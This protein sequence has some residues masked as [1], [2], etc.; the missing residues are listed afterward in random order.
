MRVRE[1]GLDSLSQG[2]LHGCQVGRCRFSERD[3]RATQGRIRRNE[4][5]CR[6][7]RFWQCG[8]R[9]ICRRHKAAVSRTGERGPFRRAALCVQ[10]LRRVHQGSLERRQVAT[11]GGDVESVAGCRRR[12]VVPTC[13]GFTCNRASAPGFRPARAGPA[14]F[15]AGRPRRPR[16]RCSSVASTLPLTR[17]TG[18]PGR[19]LPSAGSPALFGDTR[20]VGRPTWRCRPEHRASGFAMDIQD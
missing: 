15:A 8:S 3:R 16:A 6:K 20:P 13:P 11:G 18:S 12:R 7:A 5:A 9:P 4:G 14:A 10:F 19:A 17:M 2:D 1:D